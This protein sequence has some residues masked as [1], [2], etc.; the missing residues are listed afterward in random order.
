M[1]NVVVSLLILILAVALVRRLLGIERGRW[2]VTLLAVIIA[3]SAAIL[4]LRVTVGPVSD[5]PPRAV[6]G[7]LAIRQM[8]RFGR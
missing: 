1:L 3:E 2:G 8:L 5:L 7:G 4:V 6:F